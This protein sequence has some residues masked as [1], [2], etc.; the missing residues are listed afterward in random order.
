MSSWKQRKST[1]SS[2]V[3]ISLNGMT[4][5]KNLN[6][7]PFFLTNHQPNNNNNH[8]NNSSSSLLYHISVSNSG[9]FISSKED[10]KDN[11]K[12]FYLLTSGTILKPFLQE[13]ITNSS[14][15]ILQRHSSLLNSSSSTISNNLTSINDSNNKNNNLTTND[16]LINYGIE[17]QIP[18]L[19]N[20]SITITLPTN[21]HHSSNQNNIIYGDIINSTTVKHFGKK[22]YQ[23]NHNNNNVTIEC[24]G[25]FSHSVT[26]KYLSQ[27][28]QQLQGWYWGHPMINIK[29]QHTLIDNNELII[30][31]EEEKEDNTI[32]F[33]EANALEDNE[34][35][36][37][38][39]S[40]TNTLGSKITPSTIAIFSITVKKNNYLYEKLEEYIVPI[41]DTNNFSLNPNNDNSFYSSSNTT[42][43]RRDFKNL[44]GEEIEMMSSPFGLLSPMTLTNHLMKGI[45]NNVI[46]NSSNSVNLIYL[47]DIMIYPG[48]EGAPVLL[49]EN[50]KCIGFCTLPIRSLHSSSGLNVVISIEPFLPLLHNNFGVKSGNNEISHNE[51][52]S[53]I[54]VN[55]DYNN[56]YYNVRDYLA[57]IMVG[58]TWASGVLLS[59]NGYI[60]TN[61]HV[62]APF[63][64]RN[65]EG[66]LYLSEDISIIV[67]FDFDLRDNELNHK[68]HRAKLIFI[69]DKGP[70]DIAIIKV[71]DSTC[72]QLAQKHNNSNDKIGFIP[73]NQNI[74]EGED[75]F[76]VGYPLIQPINTFRS[77][78][79]CTITKGNVS[80]IVKVNNNNA[81]ICTSASVHDGNSG[82]GLF[83]SRGELVGLITSNVKYKL[84]DRETNQ[85]QPLILPKLNFSIPLVQISKL[86]EIIQSHS[87]TDSFSFELI[88]NFFKKFSN[89][90]L[91]IT[92][93]LD[94]IYNIPN[95]QLK[96][97]YTFKPQP[98]IPPVFNPQR[99]T[100][101]SL[102]K[103]KKKSN[104]N[105]ISKL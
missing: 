74:E 59:H 41:I 10:N 3:M 55:S 76:V 6:K 50:G 46:K 86:I 18:K 75:V 36:F 102:T 33:H 31:P 45:I 11:S 72:S 49:R 44:Q 19:N 17:K 99:Q 71:H 16:L 94:K 47:T 87:S 1:S 51:T 42:T 66:I 4:R 62:F 58:N 32:S 2:S 35:I 27:F 30:N 63:M 70:L 8:P 7:L 97:V 34:D 25:L 92:K 104:S 12:T 89:E 101:S 24:C 56:I 38:S 14:S 103:K 69:N 53:N 52:S 39:L 84:T 60:L 43:A 22:N 90:E 105:F 54:I 98:Q 68:F 5:N 91:Q 29:K 40:S 48:G 96:E 23:N 37:S 73:Y 81:M 15:S 57:L 85:I 100:S 67:Q 79:H 82:G 93:E 83:N 95:D 21:H 88:T 77:I 65:E 20:C 78:K 26:D 64:K 80:K 28:I 13:Q 9:Y 61:A